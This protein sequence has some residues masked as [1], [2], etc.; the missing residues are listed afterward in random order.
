V[1][2]LLQDRAAAAMMSGSTVAAGPTTSMAGSGNHGQSTDVS[3]EGGRGG[4]Y[5]RQQCPGTKGS[6]T[7]TDI[8]L[9]R[10]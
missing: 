8:G 7:A 6:G 4:L 3:G 1:S 10:C 9:H 2:K 5:L